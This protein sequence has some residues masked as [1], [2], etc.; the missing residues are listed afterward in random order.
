[1]SPTFLS[2]LLLSVF[3]SAS[4]LVPANAFAQSKPKP[5]VDPILEQQVLEVLRKNPEVIYQVL[6][7]FGEEQRAE[8][9][10]KAKAEQ[11][12]AIQKLFQ[13]PKTLIASSPTT[14]S[15]N[16]KILLVEFSDFQCPFCS[17]SNEILKQFMAKHKDKVTLVFKHFPLTQTH[18]EALPAARAS[19]A[20]QQQG[21]FWEYHDELFANQG[22]L[23]NNFYLDT[24][25]KLNLNLAKFQSDYGIA[26][27]AILNDFKLGRT[28][29]VQGT[30]ALILNGTPVENPGSIAE[31]EQLLT[32]AEEK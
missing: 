10:R 29:D 6:K 5:K 23:S 22:K 24:A 20:A 28:I 14:G 3:L 21:K 15:T 17:K 13:D 27:T 32:K 12:A 25:K 31:L 26:D 16:K 11:V 18:P 7:K 1:M 30:P 9:E 19:W 4:F 2:R 8:Q